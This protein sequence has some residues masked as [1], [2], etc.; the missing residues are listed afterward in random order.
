MS[1]PQHPDQ[2]SGFRARAVGQLGAKPTDWLFLPDP[3][4]GSTPDFDMQAF[5]Q[6]VHANAVAKGFWFD[7]G[8][9]W[10][11]TIALIHSELSE[12]LEEHRAGRPRLWYS[13]DDRRHIE[14]LPNLHQKPEGW[15]IEL[16]D[17]A[18]R[19]LDTLAHEKFHCWPIM[20]PLYTDDLHDRIATAHFY[21]SQAWAHWAGDEGI[22]LRIA[23]H[24]CLYT[25]GPDW[26][27]ILRAKHTYNKGR[28]P[29]H[30]KAY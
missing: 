11:Q 24:I 3:G 6:E 19:I 22:R 15:A 7:G 28:E 10:G 12:A 4:N 30:G 13:S 8:R 25:I 26:P 2:F 18:I 14:G 21:V 17:A 9:P 16:A 23:L 20:E 5:A 27:E 29:L 1:T